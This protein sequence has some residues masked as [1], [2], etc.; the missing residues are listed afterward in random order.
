MLTLNYVVVFIESNI[1]VRLTF[2]WIHLNN[3]IL[4]LLI[5]L[6]KESHIKYSFY[7]VALLSLNR[8]LTQSMD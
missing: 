4:N 6:G 1:T 2:S 3:I 5:Y 7:H 8:F